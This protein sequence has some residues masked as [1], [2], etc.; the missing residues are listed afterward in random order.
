MATTTTTAIAKVD[1]SGKMGASSSAT[2]D[3]FECMP[4]DHMMMIF[5]G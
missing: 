5:F 1:E 4:L 2:V 3:V